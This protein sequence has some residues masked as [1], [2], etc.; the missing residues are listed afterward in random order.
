MACV[1]EAGRTE[2]IPNAE[3]DLLTPSVVHFAESEVVVGKLAHAARV[4]HPEMVAQW[5]KRELGAALCARPISGRQR[6]PEAILAH[7]LRKLK[8]DLVQAVGRDLQTVIAVPGCFDAPRRGAL[9]E[10][11]EMADF[12]PVT[13]VK[14]STAAAL[15]YAEAVGM[16][17]PGPPQGEMTVLIYDLGSGRFDATLLRLGPGQLQTLATVGDVALGGHEWDERLV[18]WA[19]EAFQQTHGVDPRQDQSALNRLFHEAVEAKHTLTARS[20]AMMQIH[21]AGKSAEVQILRGQFEEMTADLLARTAAAAQAVL[22]AANLDW[23]RVDRLMLVGGSTRMPRVTQMLR[24]LSGKAPDRLVNPDE[25]VARGAALYAAHVL[26][27]QASGARADHEPSPAAG[28]G[29]ASGP[30]LALPPGVA[31][32]PGMAPRAK[33]PALRISETPL[34]QTPPLTPPVAAPLAAQPLAAEPASPAAPQVAP[35]APVET[36][37]AEAAAAGPTSFFA[38]SA[39]AP[40]PAP[41]SFFSAEAAPS[42]PAPFFAGAAE[43]AAAPSAFPAPEAAPAAAP[44]AQSWQAAPQPWAA[45]ETAAG[46]VE[47]PPEF[48]ANEP[49]PPAEYFGPPAFQ[50]ATPSLAMLR[51]KSRPR[52]GVPAWG[53]AIGHLIAAALGLGGACMIVHHFRPEVFRALGW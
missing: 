2:M 5:V 36:V 30:D 28:G 50:V 49:E 35:P 37:A 22:A 25:A 14:E 16:F 52:A 12:R 42:A 20:R 41:P 45:N 24:D 21:F 17:A 39:D 10:A 8:A 31:L 15:A 34:F 33:R 32:P 13:L 48:A 29:K 6:P 46:P 47:F 1:G 51:R 9:V 18:N 40:P 26:A 4:A 27:E 3:G 23:G 11:A 43:A 38:A 19:A 44:S 7:V 53:Q